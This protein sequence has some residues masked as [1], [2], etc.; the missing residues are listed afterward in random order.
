MRD[1][2]LSSLYYLD[3]NGL[4]PEKFKASLLLS[5]ARAFLFL[6][7]KQQ[8]LTKRARLQLELVH[9]ISPS[10]KAGFEPSIMRL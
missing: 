4:F 6:A 9:N 1:T 5:K 7:K 8:V 2:P 3:V 10:V